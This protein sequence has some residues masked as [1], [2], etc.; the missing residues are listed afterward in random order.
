[1]TLQP[2]IANVSSRLT[3]QYSVTIN[4]TFILRRG[5]SHFCHRKWEFSLWR[6]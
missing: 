6:V 2:T 3:L 5:R 1:M 4:H